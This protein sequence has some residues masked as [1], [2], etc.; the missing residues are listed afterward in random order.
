MAVMAIRA[1]AEDFIEKPLND[2]QLVSALNRCLAQA[3]EHLAG[4]QSQHDLERMF[5]SL[6]PAR[7][8]CSISWRRAAPARP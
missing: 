4:R 5:Q 8:R 2:A 3:F 7:S 6:R 1:G